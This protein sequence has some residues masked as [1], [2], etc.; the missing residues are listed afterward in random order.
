MPKP[1]R[2][3]AGPN[4]PTPVPNRNDRINFAAR[5]DATMTALPAAIDGVNTN[6]AYVADALDYVDE[7]IDAAEQAVDDAADQVDLAAHQVT[8]AAEQKTLAQGFALAAVNAPG[9]SSTSSTSASIGTGSRNLTTQTGKGW[10]PGMHIIVAENTAPSTRQMYG[11]L[12]AYDGGTGV[13]SFDVPFD[14]ALGSGTYSAWTISLTGPRIRSNNVPIAVTGTTVTA[15]AGGVYSLQNASAAT[16]T[17]PASPASGD[18]VTVYCSN[19]R[20]DNVL[21]RNGNNLI[22]LAENLT[23]DIPVLPTCVEFVTGYGWRFA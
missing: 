17:L 13:I 8:L 14:G 10:L 15:V 4:V 9:T 5:G 23:M 6:I 3:A 2:P 12:T 20:E 21:A 18:R 19:G 22:G 11:V 16:V 1:T 7:Q